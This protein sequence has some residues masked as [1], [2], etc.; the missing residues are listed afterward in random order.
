MNEKYRKDTKFYC[1]YCKIFVQNNK[2]SKTAHD[3]S[4]QHKNALA[5][6]LRGVHRNQDISIKEN[7][8]N[9][10]MM[11]EIEQ[12]AGRAMGLRVS[13]SRPSLTKII[14]SSKP[15]IGSINPLLYG[16]GTDDGS[17]Y[18]P[19]SWNK[20]E[21]Q[22][23]KEFTEANQQVMGYGIIGEWE[24]FSELVTAPPVKGHDSAD[25]GASRNERQETKE[26]ED[27]DEGVSKKDVTSF[28]VYTKKFKRDGDEVEVQE[29][30]LV[31]K[32]KKK[33]RE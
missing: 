4:P 8:K 27:E 23:T 20:N 6:Y 16:I 7:D 14:Q 29:Q 11:A 10:K 31:F 28:T 9:A 24:S 17:A 26:Y 2:I 3:T 19:P 1:E 13:S 12:K 25:E 5:R 30:D 21:F 33:K 22:A 15:S 32:K 18:I